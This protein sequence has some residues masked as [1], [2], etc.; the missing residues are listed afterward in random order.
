MRACNM[1]WQLI[2]HIC[3]RC[4]HQHPDCSWW[5]MDEV[6]EYEFGPFAYFDDCSASFDRYVG[7]INGESEEAGN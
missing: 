3:E 6:G 4:V 7:D 5:F 1:Q 2:N